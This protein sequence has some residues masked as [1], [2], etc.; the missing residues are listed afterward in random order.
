MLEGVWKKNCDLE[1]LLWVEIGLRAI[2]CNHHADYGKLL[3]CRN[4]ARQYGRH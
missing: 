1:W 2:S 3:V 4:N